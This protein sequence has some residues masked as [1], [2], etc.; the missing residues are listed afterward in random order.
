M[1]EGGEG[2]GSLGEEEP[3][4]VLAAPRGEWFARCARDGG[5]DVS[6]TLVILAPVHRLSPAQGVTGAAQGGAHH[7]LC[8]VRGNDALLV[9][10]GE[11]CLAWGR[12]WVRVWACRTFSATLF[13]YTI[14]LFIPPQSVCDIEPTRLRPGRPAAVTRSLAS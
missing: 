5:Q 7:I 12:V 11:G 2:R 14:L 3:H 13:S 6:H 1:Q 9:L 4:T 10:R 8:L